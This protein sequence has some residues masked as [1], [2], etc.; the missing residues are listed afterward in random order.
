[1]RSRA[2]ALVTAVL[3][4]SVF[5]SARAQLPVHLSVSGGL[6]IPQGNAGDL[7]NQGFHANAALKVILI[8]VQAEVSYDRM[9]SRGFGDALSIW[10]LGAAVPVELLPRLL[11][12]GVYAIGGAGVYHH[13]DENDVN[14]SSLGLN[15]GAGVRV[16]PLPTLQPFVEA[17]GVT[18]FRSGSRITY[19]TAGGGIRF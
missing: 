12:I 18:I 3:L 7:Y 19:F 15:A 5:S 4:L 13:G 9:S 8:P 6:L 11:P 10:A 17:R 2:A 16:K 1:M 14:P